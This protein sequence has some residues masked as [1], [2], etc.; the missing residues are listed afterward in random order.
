MAIVRSSI[1]IIETALKHNII[2]FK[3]PSFLT[4][5]LQLIDNVC[6]RLK[7]LFKMNTYQILKC[8]S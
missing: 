4:D 7:Y 6:Q 5:K 1:R 2:L 8:I 3:F